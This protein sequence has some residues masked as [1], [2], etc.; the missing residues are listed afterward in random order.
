MEKL[1]VLIVDDEPLGADVIAAHL[2]KFPHIDI[3]ASLR[4]GIDALEFL[5]HHEVDAIFLDIQMPGMTGID[6]KKQIQDKGIPVI[7]VTAYSD[8]AVEAFQ[9]EALDYLVKPVSF[10]RFKITI[11]RLQEFLTMKKNNEAEDV[12]LEGGHI[13]VKADSKYVKLG[14]DEIL[15]VEAFADYVKIYISVNPDKR[16]ITL[17]TMKNMEVTLPADKFVR[18]HRS[19][20]VAISK[21]SALSGTEVQIESKSIPIGKNYKD[22][23][24][25]AMNKKNFLK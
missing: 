12:K 2:N 23:F 1:K 14:Y 15:F 13:F 18:V 9:L 4:N 3:A 24:L 16:I 20:I 19:Y 6:M 11:E 10:D 22:A 25:S 7:F 8:Y 17:Q 21:V 5:K